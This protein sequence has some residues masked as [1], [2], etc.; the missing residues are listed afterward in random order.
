MDYM[1]RTGATDPE[2]S[3]QQGFE[4]TARQIARQRVEKRRKLHADAVA[5]VVI[6][7]FLVG[8]WAVTGMG[9]FWPAWVMAGWG[10]LLLL[11]AWEAYG[12]RPVSESDIEAELHKHQQ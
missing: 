8:V 4:S 12:R 7:V 10:V 5:Y 11:G 1:R 2:A 6:N 3:G 9:Y